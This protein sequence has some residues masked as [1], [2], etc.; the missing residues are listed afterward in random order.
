MKLYNV[1]HS[2]QEDLY[3]KICGLSYTGDLRML[4]AEDRNKVSSITPFIKSTK[5]NCLHTI[6][7]SSN[8][9]PDGEP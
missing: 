7:E 4:F 8:Y 1:F 3:A 2:M 5:G 6:G 9:V